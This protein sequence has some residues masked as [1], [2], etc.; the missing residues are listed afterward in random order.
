M[1]LE[2]ADN[3]QDDLSYSGAPPSGTHHAME[4]LFATTFRDLSQ[5]IGRTRKEV[6]V[7]KHFFG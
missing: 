3:Q 4:C 7:K 6:V 2:L 1:N 5:A